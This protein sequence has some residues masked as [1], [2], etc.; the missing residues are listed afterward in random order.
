MDTIQKLGY[1]HFPMDQ[2]DPVPPGTDIIMI[3]GPY[4]SLTP[5]IQ[6]LLDYPE[7]KRPVVVYWFQQS[8]DFR[9]PEWLRNYLGLKLSD[10]Q[11]AYPDSDGL[12]TRSENAIFDVLSFKGKR[13]GYLGDILWMHEHG[14]L[15][16]FGLSS[17]SY[18]KFFKSIGIDSMIVPRGYHPSYGCMLDQTRDIPL[19]WMGK[20]RSRRRR[21]VIYWLKGQLHKRGLEMRIHD[22]N[23]AAF[24][25]GEERTALLNR[26]WFVLNVFFSGPTD[27]LS[28][29]YFIAG[30]NGA[31]V[32]TE[33]GEN[34]YP[35][36]PGQHIVECE[37]EAM[38]DRILYY[39]ENP[40]QWDVISRNVYELVS[41]E[42]TLERSI[43]QLLERAE[44]LLE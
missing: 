3:Q 39:L 36:I 14:F 15:D 7:S 12:F 44:S 42:F 22:G 34:K 13:L 33:P 19:V 8:M 31:V 41:R 29:R 40:D 10:L 11:R 26:T 5:L 4:G 24:I 25:Y 1:R 2:H 16:V 9:R 38:P 37:F 35:F 6:Q 32:L 17:T 27:E 30:A 43:S 23:E 28:I 21:N 20:M 18:S